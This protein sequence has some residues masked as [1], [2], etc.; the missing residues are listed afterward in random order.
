MGTLKTIPPASSGPLLD[1]TTTCRPLATPP[2]DMV[3]SGCS[4]SVYVIGFG[5]WRRGGLDDGEGLGLEV[6]AKNS[7][8]TVTLNHCDSRSGFA[9]VSNKNTIA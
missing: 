7:R 9:A 5:R 8:S 2:G 1:A 3:Q 6:I 4:D